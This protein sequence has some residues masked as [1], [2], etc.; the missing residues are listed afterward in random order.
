LA[1]ADLERQLGTQLFLRHHA[2]G[3][4]L[5]DAGRR[6]APLARELLARASDL[7][8]EAREIGESLVGRLTVACYDTIAPFVVPRLITGFAERHPQVELTFR[9]GNMA[10]LHRLVRSGEAELMLCYDLD[11]GDD[12]DVHRLAPTSPYVLMAPEHPLAGSSQ[13]SLRRLSDEPMVLLDQPQS[14]QYF[15]GLFEADGV[16]PTIRYRTGS[17][18]MVRSLVARSLGYSLLIQ[19][20]VGDVSYEGLPLVCRPVRRPKRVQ[21]IVAATLAR[22][23][24]TR[25]ASAFV[26]HAEAELAAG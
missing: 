19:R 2:N 10:E 6:V 25:R 8:D 7:A 26:D 4:S 21:T 22:A 15:L 13:I 17:F 9:E 11:L 18:E 24:P 20:P 3:L 16:T 1:V 5:T 12:L 14:A 23:R